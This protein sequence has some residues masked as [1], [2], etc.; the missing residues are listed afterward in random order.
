VR[1]L[2]AASNDVASSASV[3]NAS[4]F[5]WLALFSCSSR[6]E[7]SSDYRNNSQR[8]ID[9]LC[10]LGTDTIEN[11]SPKT[12]PIVASRSYRLDRVENTASQLLHCC[13]LRIC[14]LATGVLAEPFP[15]NGCLCGLYSSCLE[16]VCDSII[17]VAAVCKYC[18]R[19][20]GCELT[21]FLILIFNT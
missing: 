10:S 12:S 13:I 1:C 20:L 2:I 7:I 4:C 9:S 18:G 11:N 6:D 14:C 17:G 5:R 21:P 8:T 3:S 19:V 15:S 16:Q